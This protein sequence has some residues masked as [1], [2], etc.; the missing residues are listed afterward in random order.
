MISR[1][2]WI[3]SVNWPRATCPRLRR[4]GRS[5][6]SAGGGFGWMRGG[7]GGSLAALVETVEDSLPRRLLCLHHLPVLANR[8]IPLRCPGNT[9][10]D[11]HIGFRVRAL[12]LE[13]HA[14]TDQS[15]VEL[16]RSAA[17]V[18]PSLVPSVP[19]AVVEI[20]APAAAAIDGRPRFKERTALQVRLDRVLASRLFALNHAPSSDPEVELPIFHRIAGGRRRGGGDLWLLSYC[21]QIP[22]KRSGCVSVAY[23]FDEHG[24]FVSQAIVP[25]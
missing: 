8:A 9:V 20:D 25:H 18:N 3:C 1:R 22:E 23:Q 2:G 16:E 10:P 11:G 24:I 17:V 14:P 13:N 15:P 6:R 21:A 7:S 12:A 4:N 5:Y 19:A